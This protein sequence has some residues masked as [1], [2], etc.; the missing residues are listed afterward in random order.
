MPMRGAGRGRTGGMTEMLG[1]FVAL[2]ADPP[3]L[4]L[5]EPTSNLD[6]EA[7]REVIGLLE[8][9]KADGK[10]LICCSH[11]LAEV[12]R[13]ADRVIVLQ[14]GRLAAAGPPH[15]VAWALQQRTVVGRAHV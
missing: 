5:D 8:E 15:S 10:T 3:I 12:W 1:L 14:Q 13:L 7:R 4:L 2:L 9:L 11:R 6:A